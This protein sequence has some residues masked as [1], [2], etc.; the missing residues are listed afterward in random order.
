MAS[1]WTSLQVTTDLPAYRHLRGVSCENGGGDF[2]K[3]TRGLGGNP[4]A[5]RNA[6]LLLSTHASISNMSS[7][8]L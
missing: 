7:S 6:L 8:W 2:D 1:V 3:A 5:R 4:G